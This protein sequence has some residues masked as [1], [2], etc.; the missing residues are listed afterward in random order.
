MWMNSQFLDAARPREAASAR[1]RGRW[2]WPQV[3]VCVLLL[4]LTALSAWLDAAARAV[5]QGNL[6]WSRAENA[7]V[8][9]FIDHVATGDRQYLEGMGE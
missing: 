9:L 7:A 2:I 8:A 5:V 6:H 1:V 3:V 4:S